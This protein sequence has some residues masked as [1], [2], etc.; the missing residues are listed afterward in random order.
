MTIKQ[1]IAKE[2]DTMPD[3]IL[4]M[5]YDYIHKLNLRYG[6]SRA[7]KDKDMEWDKL[8]AEEFLKGYSDKD[9]IYDRI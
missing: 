1:K 6:K 2:I 9:A 7:R 3:R 4:K 5:A 8:S